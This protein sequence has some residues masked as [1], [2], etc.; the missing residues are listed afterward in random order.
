MKRA[1]MIE[2]TK[3]LRPTSTKMLIDRKSGQFS[4]TLDFRIK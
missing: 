4:N 2:G 1:R 3:D